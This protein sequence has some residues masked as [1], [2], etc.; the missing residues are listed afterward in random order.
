M[1]FLTESSSHF[2]RILFPPRPDPS[3]LALPSDDSQRGATLYESFD[4]MKV[5]GE[6][7]GGREGV[8]ARRSTCLESFSSVRHPVVPVLVGSEV[9]ER[10]LATLYTTPSL[11]DFSCESGPPSLTYWSL[12]TSC[13]TYVRSGVYTLLPVLI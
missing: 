5:D 11:V 4:S 6:R 7:D 2:L 10:T 13:S 9:S 8:R 1:S 12:P 3:D